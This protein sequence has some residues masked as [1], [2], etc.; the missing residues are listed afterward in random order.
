MAESRLSIPKISVNARAVGRLRAGHL[1]IYESDVLNKDTA[2]PGALV[3]VVEAKGKQLGSALYSSSSQ[4]TLRLLGRET[5]T[6]EDDLL[7]L[8]GMRLKEAVGY[9]SRVVRDSNAHRV[10]FSEADL[11]PGLMIDRY[12]DVYTLQVLTQA[13]DRPERKQAIVRGLQELTGAEH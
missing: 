7:K 12:N 1:W 5:L 2:Q 9:R 11:L 13:W 10:V 4:I 8:L 6:T 3:Q